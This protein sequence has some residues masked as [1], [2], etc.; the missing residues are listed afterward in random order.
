MVSINVQNGK[1]YF[2]T[3]TTSCMYFYKTRTEYH[4][5]QSIFSLFYAGNIVLVIKPLHNPAR[6]S[7]QDVREDVRRPNVG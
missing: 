7:I 2:R 1:K 4:A 5:Q 6:S 3:R